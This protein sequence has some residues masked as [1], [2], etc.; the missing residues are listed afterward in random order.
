MCH[1]AALASNGLA[2]ETYAGT[3]KGGA[4]GPV[5]VPGDAAGSMLIVVQSASGHAGQ[6]SAEELALVTA[7][8]E[9]GA[10]EN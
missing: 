10:L 3:L 2:L 7:W 9:A 8:I 1:G 5:I 6:L 4:D